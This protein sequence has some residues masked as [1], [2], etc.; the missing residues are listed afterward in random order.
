MTLEA[1]VQGKRAHGNEEAAEEGENLLR[2]FG[3]VPL[4]EPQ[5]LTHERVKVYP[6]ISLEEEF[7]RQRPLVITRV[8]APLGFSESDASLLL[9]TRFPER[10][11]SFNDD[12]S[13]PVIVPKFS[14][15]WGETVDAAELRMS[16]YLRGR[17][18]ELSEWKDPRGIATPDK[19]YGAWLYVG[20]DYFYRK[21]SD[22]RDEIL[23]EGDRRGGGHWDGL[24]LSVVREDIVKVKSFDLIGS[25][26]GQV[27]MACVYWWN[28]R[29]L[30]GADHVDLETPNFRS[31][32]CGSEVST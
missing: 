13:V 15:P 5:V 25:N 3:E 7:V 22:V 19:P 12:N 8:A 1:W 29:P 14:F 26:V 21:P 31:L 23:R 16:D 30:F 32:V 18:P 24:A 20:D 9:P 27:D 28:D 2:R 11:Q 17:L 10:P 6:E 4:T